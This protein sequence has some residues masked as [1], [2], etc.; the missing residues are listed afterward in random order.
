MRS[1][2]TLIQLQKTRVDEQRQ[3]LARLQSHLDEVETSV[4]EHHL[5]CAREQIAAQQNPEYALTYGAFVR[6]SIERSHELDKMLYSAKKAVEIA[7]D[8]LA[9]I[10]EEQKRY[11]IAQAARQE[12]ARREALRHETLQL[13]EVGSI[14]F[15]RKKKKKI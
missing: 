1:L 11:E 13:D 4:A 15:L 8:Q 7:R 6:W 3:L 12:K 10:F 2:S 14:S 9:Q 5:R